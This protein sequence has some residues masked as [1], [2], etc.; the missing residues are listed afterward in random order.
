MTFENLIR[1]IQKLSDT[2]PVLTERLRKYV[3]D[4]IGCC[5]EVHRD[6]GP[7]LNEYMYQ[8]ALDI[9][10]EEHGFVGE[11]KKREYYFTVDYHGKK[12]QHPHK[13]D[14][15]INQKVFIECKA[16]ESIGSEQRQQLWNYMRLT[17]TRLGILYNFAPTRD[18]S[19]HY[20]FDPETDQ[21][22]AF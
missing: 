2:D 19:E 1:N 16:I 18:Q 6:M 12:I 10:L 17:K 14:F 8:E 3:Y 9:T 22:Y 5:Q 11:N 21:M 4:I 20:Y 15:F 7:Y 13:V